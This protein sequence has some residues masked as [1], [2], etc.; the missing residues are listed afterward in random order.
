[1]AKFL[2][3]AYKSKIIILKLDDDLLQRQI[4]LLT[5]IELMEMM[6]SYYKETCEVLIYYPKIGGRTEMLYKKTIGN[7]FHA[8][9]DVHRKMFIAEFPRDGVIC[10]IKL[11][12][13]FANMTSSDKIRYDRIFQQISH[14]GGE[15]AIIYIKIFQNAQD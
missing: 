1:M 8:N 5:F 4:F 14:K 2:T 13:H 3:T 15:S 6:F 9:I 12:S 7:L 10:I 11:Q